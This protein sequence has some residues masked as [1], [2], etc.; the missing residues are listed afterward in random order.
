MWCG[1]RGGSERSVCV[2]RDGEAGSVTRNQLFPASFGLKAQ[3]HKAQGFQP[4]V[5]ET[6]QNVRPERSRDHRSELIAIAEFL[7]T[8]QVAY[9]VLLTFTGLKPCALCSWAF[10]PQDA[11]DCGIAKAAYMIAAC[12][13]VGTFKRSSP[14]RPIATSM[15][16][17]PTNQPSFAS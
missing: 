15:A 13:L 6:T 14:D 10:S 8:F 4:C 16:S 17:Q 2:K 9:L 5:R 11:G 1:L 7:A 3:E 12:Q